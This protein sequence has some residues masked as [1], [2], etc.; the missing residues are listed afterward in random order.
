MK[1]HGFRQGTRTRFSKKFGKK[2]MPT[3]GK[4]LQRFRVGDCV[5]CKV[6][7]SIVKGMPHKTFHGRTGVVFN[8]N[9]RAYGVIF[10]KRVRG[11]I[12]ECPVHVRVEHLCKSRCQEDA[13]ARYEEFK[14]IS[15]EAKE[16]GIKAK[17]PKRVPEQPREA[18]TILKANN[19]P[20]EIAPKPYLPIF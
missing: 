16:K 4:I 20:I 1:N 15:A 5:D 2:G 14:K 7:P 12:I 6:D 3:P 8:A 18:F 19:V 9:P 13:K 17:V 10:Y 11:S